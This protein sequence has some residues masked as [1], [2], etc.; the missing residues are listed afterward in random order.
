MKWL[1]PVRKLFR[2]IQCNTTWIERTVW[3]IYL[4]KRWVYGGSHM[5]GRSLRW[6]SVRAV[7]SHV[8][9]SYFCNERAQS[10]SMFNGILIYLKLLCAWRVVSPGIYRHVV[11][12]K[13]TDVSEQHVAS[14]FRIE[15]Q[16]KEETSM[17]RLASRTCFFCCMLVFCLDNSSTPKI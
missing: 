7:T 1:W 15:E 9:L 14:I 10:R 6:Y 17:K 3:R 13:S 16:P 8:P 5:E 2:S 12:C 11:R 4:P